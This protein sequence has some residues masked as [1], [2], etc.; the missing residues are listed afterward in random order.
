MTTAAAPPLPTTPARVWA[1]RAPRALW[2][3][4]VGVLA[5]AALIVTGWGVGGSMS[6]YYGSIALSMSQNW[7]NFFFGAFDPSGT[8]TLDKIPGSFWIPALFIRVFGFSPWATVFPNAL[9]AAASVVIVAFSARRWAGP[10]AGLIAGAVVA[11]TP[12]L[13]AVA[14][15][16]QPQMF[17]VLTLALTAWAATRALQRRSLGWLV[18]AG[19]FIAAGFHTYMLEAW[20]AWPALAAAYLCTRQ[21]WW[22]RLRDLAIA[23]STSLALSLTWIVA[24][25]LIPASDRPYIGSTVSNNPWEMVFGYNGLG[26]FGQATAD[27]AAYLSFTPRFS[28]DPSPL[29]LLNDAL[30]AQI[31][32]MLPV[33][34]AAIVV[35]FV[36]RFRRPLLVFG[37][38]WFA[39]FAVM[40]SVVAGMHQFYTS[41]LA[42]PMALLIGTAFTVARRRR[43]LWAQL[44]LPG[45]AAVTALGISIVASVGAGFSLPVALV[46]LVA[47]AVVVVLVLR[48]HA[49]R[50]RMPV[51]T[52]I[53]VI[54]LLLTPA[55]WSAATIG[56]PNSTNP[57]AAGVSASGSSGSAT[58]GSAPTGTTRGGGRSQDG[59]GR[60]GGGGTTQRGGGGTTQRDDGGGTTQRGG[61]TQSGSGTTQ[62]GGGGQ[63]ST[64]STIAWLQE[65]RDGAS[66]LVAAFGAQTAA[67]L[68]IASGG[69][70]VLPIG[71]FNSRDPVP[72]LAEFEQLVASGA[73]RY[74]LVSEGAGS[75][76]GADGDSTSSQI[77]AWVLENCATAT[78]APT[79]TLYSCGA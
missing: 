31:G 32:W 26:R 52:A 9:A 47:A 73:V 11:T 49:R 38:V 7:S 51:T 76:R 34:V 18:L 14:R 37:A 61:G 54:A 33:T 46:Q 41:A 19:V 66:Y 21:T 40:F 12:I 64:A 20:A 42:V 27:E 63:G 6:D 2:S 3:C 25:S 10:T 67:G 71:G 36:L 57:T 70:E 44:I 17:F 13:V 69:E 59:N 65:H 16:N 23:G 45:T 68:I 50:L 74:V 15:S 48:E 78:D 29:R 77:R 24:V 43:S 62:R 56:T 35:L 30:A 58:R 60:D 28:G 22:R 4:G 75:M 79:T 53:T 5:V 55:A 39:T 1:L 72:T 8:V